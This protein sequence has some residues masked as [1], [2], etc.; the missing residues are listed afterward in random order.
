MPPPVLVYRL[1]VPSDTQT[2]LATPPAIPSSMTAAHTFGNRSEGSMPKIPGDAE[3]SC[4]RRRWNASSA[5]PSSRL[6]RPN[7]DEKR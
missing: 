5:S 4:W 3:I 2:T 1:V 7:I 6:R